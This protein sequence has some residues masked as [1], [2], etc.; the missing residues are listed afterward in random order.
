MACAPD[1]RGRLDGVLL[2]ELGVAGG[3]EL[4]GRPLADLRAEWGEL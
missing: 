1:H 2:T 3:D 4:L